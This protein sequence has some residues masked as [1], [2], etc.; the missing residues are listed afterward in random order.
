MRNKRSIYTLCLV[1]VSTVLIAAG[2]CYLLRGARLTS[3]A[4]AQTTQRV[5]KIERLENAPVDVLAVKIDGAPVAADQPFEAAPDW[6]R[7]LI[8]EVRNASDQPITNVTARLVQKGGVKGKPGH[9]ALYEFG[10]P[11]CAP[12]TAVRIAPGATGILI[13]KV[14]TAHKAGPDDLRPF[15]LFLETVI[16]NGDD[17]RMWSGGEYVHKVGEGRWVPDPRLPPAMCGR[18][19]SSGPPALSAPPR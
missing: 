19:V 16:W 4:A 13:F 6:F 2:A 17:S 7:K 15:T 18:A 8:I 10:A 14:G 5:L 9:G 11:D 1:A 12:D 3:V